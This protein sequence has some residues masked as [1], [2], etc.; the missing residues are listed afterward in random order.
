VSEVSG[1][2]GSC[3]VLFENVSGFVGLCRVWDGFGYLEACWELPGG[4]G[5]GW[6][7]RS[8]I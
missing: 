3:R 2:V 8:G 6:G 5:R 1:F 7:D 4:R